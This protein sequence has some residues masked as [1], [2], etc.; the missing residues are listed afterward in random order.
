MSLPTYLLSFSVS[1]LIPEYFDDQNITFVFRL[2]ALISYVRKQNVCVINGDD[3]II[4]YVPIWCK[5]FF[6]VLN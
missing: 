5:Y 6:K 4:Y 3:F 2:L 1:I